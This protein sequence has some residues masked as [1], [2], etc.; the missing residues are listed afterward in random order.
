MANQEVLNG[1]ERYK[2][3]L[4]FC[5]IGM[6]INLV[7]GG[8]KVFVGYESGF[9]SIMGD[10]FNNIT[11]VGAVVLL[12]MTFY[13]AAKPSD[14]EH[15]FGLGRL[16]YI[17]ASVISAIIIYVGI[18]LFIKSIDQIRTPQNTEFTWITACLLYTSDAADE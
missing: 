10:G 4:W 9:V 16:E 18:T 8:A 6:L 1:S 13:Y 2:K 3:S 14:A 17:N 5:L 12:A 15:P 7:L 11:D